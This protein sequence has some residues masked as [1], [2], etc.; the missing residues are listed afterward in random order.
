VWQNLLEEVL[1]LMDSEYGFVGQFKSDPD[2]TMYLHC[3]HVTNIAWDETSRK[4][5]ESHRATG[6]R[7]YNMNTLWVSKN[8]SITHVGLA[9]AYK[10][11]R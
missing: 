3:S 7:F 10:I 2:G 5:Y 1:L 9:V 6:F 11:S 8:E 4:F